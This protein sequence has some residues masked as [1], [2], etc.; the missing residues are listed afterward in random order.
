MVTTVYTIIISKKACKIKQNRDNNDMKLNNS[1]GYSLLSAWWKVKRPLRIKFIPPHT[2]EGVRRTGEGATPRH[3][4]NNPHPKIKLSRNS[5]ADFQ[6]SPK[7][8]GEL[9]SSI[10]HG[11]NCYLLFDKWNG[12]ELVCATARQG[13]PFSS[14]WRW[15]AQVNQRMRLFFS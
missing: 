5:Q 6:P 2:G 14:R 10:W 9:S 8:R 3:D 15:L 11:E 7:G 12:S 13:V 4:R 1:K